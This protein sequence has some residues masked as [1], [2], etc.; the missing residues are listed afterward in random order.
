MPWSFEDVRRE[1]L[2]DNAIAAKEPEIVAA[3]NRC[4]HWL[5][6]PWMEESRGDVRG[7]LPTLS[8]L[9]IG[10]WLGALEGLAGTNGLVD[11]IRR[12]DRSAIV[13]LH[14]L[15][16]LRTREEPTIELFPEVE[17]RSRVRRPDFRVKQ[18]ETD[19]VYVEVTQA[20]EVDGSRSRH[21]SAKLGC[22]QANPSKGAIRHGSYHDRSGSGEACLSGPWS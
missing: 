20:D 12:H 18:G 6:R 15:N 2:L 8:T 9:N 13:E 22:C 14:A 7:A 19:W 4:E 5:G 16:L 3:F 11:K 1:W 17:V 10:R 21:L